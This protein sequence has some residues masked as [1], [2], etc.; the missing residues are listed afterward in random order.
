MSR[1]DHAS[2][3]DRPTR[4]TIGYA[5]LFAIPAGIVATTAVD[6]LVEARMTYALAAGVT[7]AGVVAGFVLLLTVTGETTRD[8]AP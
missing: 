4:S 5:L 2:G 7:T 8:R 1:P 6:V 3:V